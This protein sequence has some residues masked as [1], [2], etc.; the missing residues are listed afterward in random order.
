MDYKNIIN[1]T[2]TSARTSYRNGAEHISL[3]FTDP[4]TGKKIMVSVT[5]ERGGD[6]RSTQKKK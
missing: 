4:I 1:L 2:L 6:L 3:T 5:P